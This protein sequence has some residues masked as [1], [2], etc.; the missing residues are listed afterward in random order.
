MGVYT[1]T[2]THMVKNTHT[3]KGHRV[4]L[5]S[6]SFALHANQT[7]SIL[8]GYLSS[9]QDD[10]VSVVDLLLVETQCCWGCFKSNDM[11]S[12]SVMQHQK[13]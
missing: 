9:L 2:Y 3:G 4:P 13:E 8:V 10:V 12:L 5:V 11:E 6:D 1:H 7:A